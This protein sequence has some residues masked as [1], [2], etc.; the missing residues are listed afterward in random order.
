MNAEVATQGGQIEGR[1][2][3]TGQTK[4]GPGTM[5]CLQSPKKITTSKVGQQCM[6]YSL[7]F[8]V[9]SCVRVLSHQEKFTEH[10]E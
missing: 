5:L 7:I 3:K 4:N 8:I 6:C 10:A 1:A 2:E 9:L